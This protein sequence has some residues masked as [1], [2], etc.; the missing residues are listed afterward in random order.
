MLLLVGPVSSENSQTSKFLCFTNLYEL[1][2]L[3]VFL[4]WYCLWGF[5]CCCFKF[6]SFSSCGNEGAFCGLLSTVC[7]TVKYF[8]FRTFFFFL[9]VVL[10]CFR[11]FLGELISGVAEM[12]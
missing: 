4:F 6:F 3:E 5:L 7:L 2:S 9:N 10:S 1:G 8:I 11:K 12:D